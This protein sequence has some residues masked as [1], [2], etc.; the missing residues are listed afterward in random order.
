MVRIF[1]DSASVSRARKPAVFGLLLWPILLG[2]QTPTQIS[3]ILERLDRLEKENQALTEEVKALRAKLEGP[4]PDAAAPVPTGGST[5]AEAPLEEQV[6]VQDRRIEEQAQS[7]VE[8]SQR[9][10]IRVTGMALFNAYE[11]S[12][13]S[14]GSEYPV[15]ASTPGQAAAGATLRQTILGLDYRGPTAVWGATVHGS[16][17]MDFFPTANN[18]ALR[19]RTAAA[20]S[21]GP[22]GVVPP[23]AGRAKH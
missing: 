17:Y 8:A 7:K 5:A 2:A 23:G 4:E 3:G 19:M 10:P 12:R 22:G 9:F 16:V 11:N 14:S 18:G 15:T 13:Q 6:R 20:G 1:P 21:G